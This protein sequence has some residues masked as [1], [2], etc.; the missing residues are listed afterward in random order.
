[1]NISTKS[2]YELKHL[3]T[4]ILDIENALNDADVVLLRDIIQKSKKLGV[5]MKSNK[6]LNQVNLNESELKEQFCI[7]IKEYTKIV[8]DPPTI[9]CISCERLFCARDIQHYDQNNATNVAFELL[10]IE[11][12]N[13]FQKL[14]KLHNITDNS[15]CRPCLTNLRKNIMP[16]NCIL[17]NLFVGEVPEEIRSLNMI[18][19]ILIQRAKAFQTITKLN[20]VMNKN[21]P[22]YVKIDKVIGR[23]FHLPLPLEETL[24]K[25]C[26]DTDPINADHELYIL[27]RTHPTKANKI[28]EDYIDINKVWKAL[29]WLKK[30]NSIYE[31]IEL[32]SNPQMLLDTLH[33]QLEYEE[34]HENAEEECTPK[35]NTVPN[36]PPVRPLLTQ[37]SETD[38]FYDHYT[39]YPLHDKKKNESDTALYQMLQVSAAALDNRGKDLDLKCFPD[40]YP[41]GKYG[42]HAERKPN[43]RDFDYIKSRLASKHSQFRLNIQYLF[44]SLYNNTLR[45]INAGIFQMLNIINPRYKYTVKEF[46][47]MLNENKLDG[48]LDTIFSRLPGTESYW[49]KVRNEL[50]C[51]ARE[52]GP[53]TF[54]ITFSP[55]EWMW[56]ALAEYIKQVNGWNDSRSIS[57]LIAADPVSTARYFQNKFKAVLAYILSKSNPIGK[58]THYYW[59]REYQGRG[60]PHYHCL[61]WIQDA[62][63]YGTSS[64][65]EVQEF[66]LQHITCHILDKQISPEL[67]RRVLA[68]Q[69]H[70]H[71]DYCMRK[72]QTKTGFS[73]A[74]RFGF[75]RPVTDRIILRD[76]SVAISN[77]NKLKNK[78]RFYDLPRTT[79]EQNINDYMPALLLIWEGNNDAQYIGESSYLLTKYVSKYGTKGE[80]SNLD[81]ADIQS[82]KPLFNRLWAFA[83]RALQHRECGAIEAADVLLGHPLHSTDPETIVKWLNVNIIR[84]R[85]LKPFNEIKNLP[86]DSTDLFYDSFID[87]HYP[88][89]PKE[90]DSLCLYD[91]AKWFEI[92]KKNPIYKA[93][94]YEMSNGLYCKKRKKPYLIN[95][96]QFNPNNQLEAYYHAL[97]LLFKPWRDLDELKGSDGTYCES[98]KKQQHELAQAMKYHDKCTIIQE[99]MDNMNKLIQNQLEQS[100]ADTPKNSAHIPDGCVPIEVENAMNDF[101]AVVEKAIISKQ[102]LQNSIAKFNTD[103]LRVF[104]K[105]TSVIQ[106]NSKILR[107]FV[108]GPGGTGKSFV[109]ENLVSWNKIHRCKDTAVT[110]PTGIAAYNIQ[111]LTIHRLLQ[112]PV[113]HGGTA[114]YKELS[115]PA[116]KQIRQTLQNVDLI[117]IDE[118][119][120]VSNITFM[121]IHLRLT[122]IFDTSDTEDGWFGKINVLVFGDLLQLPPVRED[123][124]FVGMKK[125]QIDKYIKSMITFNLW[126]L[127]EYDELTINMR[128]K[129]D[130]AYSEILSRIRL[131]FMTH[132][133]INVLKTR[134]IDFTSNDY[135]KNIQELCNYL[136][137]LPVDTVCLLPTKKMCNA[138]NEAMMLTIDSEEIN[139]VAKDSYKCEKNLQ[140]KVL[141]LLNDDEDNFCGIDRVITIKIGSKVM[142][143]RNIDVSIGLVN[144]TIGTVV[145]LSKDRSTEITSIRIVLQSGKEHE[146]PR[147]EY[148]FIIMDKISITR[149]Q[150]PICNSYGIT[151]HKSQGL[152]LTNAVVEAGNNVFSNGQTYVAASRVTTLEGLHLIN[153]DPSC[154][155]ADMTAI[156]EY[157]RLRKEYRPDLNSFDIPQD[158]KQIQSLK[159][160][161]G[162]D[163]RQHS[164]TSNNY[165]VNLFLPDFRVC[166]LQQ[167]IDYNIGNWQDIENYCD[168]GCQLK[169]IKKADYV[170]S[171]TLVILQLMLFDRT[172]DN[173]IVKITNL[174]INGIPLAK[175]DING[176]KYRVAS[177]IFH[178]GNISQG[179]YT[180]MLRQ[181]NQWFNISDNDVTKKQWPRGAKNVYILFLEQ[182]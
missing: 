159:V 179:H 57:Q 70:K 114:E 30:N 28:W 16:S 91:F 7:G 86:E 18:E 62:P 102:D 76:V 107:M 177:G 125:K 130:Q 142:L 95:H 38:P 124:V 27:I 12:E 54:F 34:N 80:K 72:K 137:K 48:N 150:F 152:S 24:K 75:P 51:M 112:L 39:I 89:R 36:E 170:I 59:V 60:L 44:F 126:E 96:Y 49:K 131:G 9:P 53:A 13:L 110:A 37:K 15:I 168:N 119:S 3:Y 45:Q 171:N 161:P 41:Y 135:S 4:F 25:I 73:T 118:I 21:I 122:E 158:R 151:I 172:D 79:D 120:M 8:T 113:E 181:H 138:I 132:S 88:N 5:P 92:S 180:N 166:T 174:K 61:F 154:C 169:K 173:D 117:I 134:K 175:V 101:Q 90:L 144:G 93:E 155:T 156:L 46:L 176:K 52:Y 77:R 106:S 108:S 167:I 139:L 136:K 83:V 40:L 94:Y 153:F 56:S 160:C 85:K 145:S 99:A 116:L 42:Q 81:F 123:F 162:C 78:S 141:K 143:R 26:P 29:Q 148:K 74:C 17:N 35:T 82:N 182:I 2:L 22:H 11:R 165:I 163:E 63:I 103:Q 109:I 147:L 115:G 100:V 20:T 111:G 14:K 105:I 127:F 178:H 43:L 149:E 33:E 133:D 32:P 98:F 23:T 104:N 146:I 47:Q 68:Y 129:N 67:H 87:N 164:N 128:Q 58:V 65:E 50:R 55:G 64:N 31:K 71:N 69:Q 1:M 66:I 157:N 121:Y 84:G 140:K 10:G 97:L 19:K 6:N